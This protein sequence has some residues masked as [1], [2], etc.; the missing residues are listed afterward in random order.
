MKGKNTP[1]T[2]E[3]LRIRQSGHTLTIT[4]TRNMPS[5]FSNEEQTAFRARR[6]LKDRI[7]SSFPELYVN[8]P[9]LFD[10]GW[11]IRFLTLTFKGESPT[12][13]T[14]YKNFHSFQKR[15]KRQTEKLF[16][17]ESTEIRYVAIKER[18]GEK[19]R[20]HLH[21]I[22]FSPFFT[23]AKWRK[24]W[25]WG[26][27]NIAIV[28]ELDNKEAALPNIAHY[29]CKYFSKRFDRDDNPQH[30]KLMD[31]LRGVDRGKKRFFSSRN[32]IRCVCTIKALDVTKIDDVFDFLGK[33]FVLQ[34]ELKTPTAKTF[35]GSFPFSYKQE[36]V[37]SYLKTLAPLTLQEIYYS[38]S[39]APF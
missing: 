32:T 6:S 21:L 20:L 4:Q 9:F 38:R 1:A 31:G 39:E 25:K 11:R 37:K 22:I 33:I 36:D 26:A 13:D 24:M 27:I 3:Q 29:L 28:Q 10:A 8:F 30:L 2:G 16:P 15:L 14:V 17:G 5:S 12:H 35:F 19:N 7:N 18:G 34:K 23:V